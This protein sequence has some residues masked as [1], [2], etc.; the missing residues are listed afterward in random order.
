MA[1]VLLN[2]NS[3][4]RCFFFL[5]FHHVTSFLIARGVFIFSSFDANHEKYFIT[6]KCKKKC[7]SRK[8][9]SNLFYLWLLSDQRVQFF[10]LSRVW[11]RG[12]QRP[13]ANCL[14]LLQL[15]TVTKNLGNTADHKEA[16]ALAECPTHTPTLTFG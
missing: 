12:E 3:Y 6:E 9:K 13:S 15:T 5:P 7:S 16:Q 14:C 2:H 1:Q 11:L 10:L 8:K 4:S